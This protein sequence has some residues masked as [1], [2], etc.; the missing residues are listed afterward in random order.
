MALVI[1]L[2]PTSGVGAAAQR[3]AAVTAAHPAPSVPARHVDP[4]HLPP[5][6]PGQHPAMSRPFH[7]GPAPSPSVARISGV[8][9]PAGGRQSAQPV[10][11]G[12]R[13]SGTGFATTGFGTTFEGLSRATDASLGGNP[14]AEPADAQLAAGPTDLV[15]MVNDAGAIYDKTGALIVSFDLRSLFLAPVNYT[16]TS[17]HLIF[18]QQSGR[19]FATVLAFD[20]LDDSQVYTAVSSSSDPTQPWTVYTVQANAS[21]TLYDQPFIGNAD[22]K[23]V[24]SWSD[25]PA[26]GVFAGSE[27]L[28]LQKSD[29]LAAST[30]HIAAFPVNASVFRMAPAKANGATPIA[31]AVANTT[32]MV[33]QAFAIT[34]TPLAS[35]V[36]LIETDLPIAAFGVPPPPQQSGGTLT[37]QIDTR[38]LSA[39]WQNNVLWTSANDGCTPEGDSSVHDC[40]RLIEVG[41]ASTPT[42]LQDFDVAQSGSDFSYPA[43][44]LDSLGDLTVVFTV[45]GRTFGPNI[46]VTTQLAGSAGSV[47][48]AVSVKGGP[49]SSVKAATTTS[50][51]AATSTP[52][53]AAAAAGVTT[54]TTAS[55][56]IS[57]LSTLWIG[58]AY[59]GSRWGDYMAVAIDPAAAGSVWV[60]GEYA[61][62]DEAPN[63]GTYIAQVTY[64][65]Y[66]GDWLSLR[67]ETPTATSLVWFDGLSATGYDLVR[68]SNAG[69]TIIGPLAE[70]SYLDRPPTTDQYDC[71]VVAPLNGATVVGVS[72]MLCRIPHIQSASGVPSD[73][74]INLGSTPTA[75]LFWDNI[76]VNQSAYQLLAI[77]LDGSANRVINLASFFGSYSDATAGKFTCYILTA[78]SGGS[79]VGNTDAICGDPGVSTLNAPAARG[80]PTLPSLTKVQSGLKRLADGETR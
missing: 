34:G 11:Q 40:L 64:P 15:E 63:W 39:V 51:T 49:A 62:S 66:G 27:T 2:V 54:A 31:Y 53:P 25:Y 23:I 35:N 5:S 50:V 70:D 36:Q 68:L 59:K 57:G 12:S 74:T 9:S 58:D 13:A 60:D 46:F 41:T 22:D 77:P 26:N 56:T 17:P 72:N 61:T 79:A 65:Q 52:R 80:I 73:F 45:S 19:W 37:S 71:Y 24:L 29:M 43:A 30:L 75:T 8:V 44:G 6:R 55:A 14:N 18:D 1:G 32:G 3:T 48:P 4:L 69:E 38:L 42:K 33:L 7:R 10:P 67:A 20:S 47:G 28:V 78:F 76:S 16:I 21:G